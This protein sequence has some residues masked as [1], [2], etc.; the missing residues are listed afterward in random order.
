MRFQVLGPL[1]VSADDR[2]LT[3]GARQQQIL[4]A[5]LCS[6]ANTAIH[7]DRL[8][9]E[10]WG[11][12]PPRSAHHLVQVYVS[13]LRKLL[14][15]VDG[16]PRIVLEP[17]G[18]VLRVDAEELD[19]L[20]LSSLAARARDLAD[21]EQFAAWQFLEQAAA[22]WRGKPFGDLA[23]ESEL[24]R[25]HAAGLT[26]IY[27]NAVEDRIEV[28]L[29]LGHHLELA[30]ELENL[31]S[32]HPY[33]ERL[34]RLLMLAHYRAGRQV[35][36][37]RTFQTLRQTLGEDLGIEPTPESADLEQAILLHDPALLWEPPPP[38]STLPA[39][40]TS[41]VGRSFEISEVTKL[42]DTARIVT[43]TGSGGIG[44][45][46]L[47]IEAARRVRQRF[48]D[49]LWWIDLAS[50][51]R[52]EDVVGEVAQALGVAT[53]PGKTLTET[54]VQSLLRRTA[55]LVIDNCEHVADG[56]AAFVTAALQNADG[57]R[58]LATSR[59]P[60]RV[61]GESLWIVPSLSL[62]SGGPEATP[63]LPYSDAIELFVERGSTVAPWFQLDTENS[64]HIVAICTRLDGL[65]LAIEMAAAHLRVMTP[66]EIADALHNRFAVL[67]RREREEMA[68]HGTLRT[69][70]DWSYGLLV[71]EAQQA[72]DNLAVFPGSFSL[73]A[74]AHI[75]FTHI[76]EPST[77]EMMTD[78]VEASLVT[79]L[80]HAGNARFRLLETLREYALTNLRASG[81]LAHVR[82]THAEYFVE[83]FARAG[84]D[85]GE[86]AFVDWIG[87]F[88][89][90]YGDVQQAIDWFF[91][92]GRAV[93]A[94]SLAPPLM[95]FWMRTGSAPEARRWGKRMVEAGEIAAPAHQAAAHS[96]IA[97]AGTILANDPQEVVAHADRAIALSRESDDQRELGVALFVRA[98]V[99]LM[100]GDFATVHEVASEGL[101]VSERI[102]FDWGRGGCLSSLAFWHFYGGGSLEEA[103]AMAVEAVSI[104]RAVG[105]LGGQV[106]LNPVAA[107]A[108]RQGDLAAAERYALD[109][110]AVASGT[111]W[112]ATAL[113]NLAEVFLARS[114]LNKAD[115][116]LQRAAVRA[117]DTGLENWFRIALR[118]MAQ[119]ALQRGNAL[120]ATTLM[121]ASR[122]NMPVWGLDPA[123][124]GA[125]EDGAKE[126]LS[127]ASFKE[128]AD[129]GY[130]L[131]IEE[132]LQLALS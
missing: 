105:D 62:P 102:G 55:L 103:R 79:T 42:I 92:T 7:P 88:A 48:P 30:E 81:R 115:S 39:S 52:G 129:A 17:A 74:A 83:S 14:G 77:R 100:V 73:D 54:V 82:A 126:S 84:A 95:H 91:E 53:Q 58:V 75:A 20:Q 45:T 59:T 50:L 63:G 16:Q 99:A 117:L 85:V 65:P 57:V 43:L 47:A 66:S 110:A 40:L 104:F 96:A 76:D 71:P 38:P 15:E 56:V 69:A 28:G 121:G 49:G 120:A 68:R 67:V 21:D 131:S 123:I 64:A 12:S 34:W 86:P 25:T 94:L 114:E 37:L 72:F 18:Y 132:L 130:E 24:L 35:E 9:D 10:I 89:D 32:H 6:A 3:L 124:Y 80:D 27:L 116:T 125:I 118:D 1:R 106:V 29:D 87:R 33:R 31:T 111:G 46:R 127:E 61:S 19:A 2:A 44:K 128:A 112:E 41:F 13:R 23:D 11:E 98:N 26:E 122:R 93:E 70:L 113:V 51:P 90:S 119:L 101:R 108:L 78:L 109:T 4:L 60:L 22:L 8:V 107:I 36:A 5:L 97:F